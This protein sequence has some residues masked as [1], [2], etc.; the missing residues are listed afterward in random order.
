MEGLMET[1]AAS[2]YVGRVADLV[3]PYMGASPGVDT[4]RRA[5]TTGGRDIAAW[6]ESHPGRWALVFENGMGTLAGAIKKMGYTFSE[7]DRDTPY[8]R[9]YAQNP[10]PEAES[11]RDAL[12]RTERGIYLPKLEVDPFGWTPEE[13]AEAC[14]I[15]RDNLFPTDGRWNAKKRRR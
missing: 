5:R 10:H 8:M 9:V 15:A 7:R 11:L 3:N 2:P 6:L 1:L 12:A 14:Q 13:L 4:G